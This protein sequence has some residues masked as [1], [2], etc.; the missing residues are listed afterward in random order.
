MRFDDWPSLMNQAIDAARDM[1]FQ[2]GH[3]DCALFAADVV[4]AI[5]GCD[6]AQSWRGRY[7]DPFSLLRL[8]KQ[9]QFN[10]LTDLVDTYLPR[11]D[12]APAGRGDV[13]AIDMDG[14]AA[15][16]ICAGSD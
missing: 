12:C 14:H 9:H 7:T 16:G 8:L 1:P 15:L 13:V 6:Y 2:W 10:E 5:T 3:H 4:K 11:I